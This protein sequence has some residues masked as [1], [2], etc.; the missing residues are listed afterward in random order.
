MGEWPL[1]GKLVSGGH[2]AGVG[3]DKSGIRSSSHIYNTVWDGHLHCA[4]LTWKD[5]YQKDNGTHSHSDDTFSLQSTF[6]DI[7]FEESKVKRR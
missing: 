6:K 4:S 3:A 7:L 5:N 2:S 1:D